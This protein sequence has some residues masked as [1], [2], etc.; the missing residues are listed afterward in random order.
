[1]STRAA[2]LVVLTG[3]FALA[4][5]SANGFESSAQADAND[6]APYFGKWKLNV[7]ESDFGETTVAF[8]RVASGEMQ[9]TYLGRSYRFRVRW[10]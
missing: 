2:S 1:M 3:F 8:D 9:M 6:G 4:A 5:V 10:Q 7:A